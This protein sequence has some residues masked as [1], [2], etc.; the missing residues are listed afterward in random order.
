VSN[1]AVPTFDITLAVHIT[2]K[3]AW[4]NGPHRDG[5]V[6]ATDALAIWF[7]LNLFQRVVVGTH[8]FQVKVISPEI[9]SYALTNQLSLNRPEC[10][11]FR[12]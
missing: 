10:V 11:S 7:S 12:L 6:F 4:L 8:A 1:I 9:A 5:V 2:V 3:A